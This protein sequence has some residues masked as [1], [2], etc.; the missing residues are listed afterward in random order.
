MDHES[1]E[2]RVAWLETVRLK[3]FVSMNIDGELWCNFTAM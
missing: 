2:S 3:F 1:H